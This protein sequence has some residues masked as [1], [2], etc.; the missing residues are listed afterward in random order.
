MGVTAIS[1][2]FGALFPSLNR[3]SK[4]FICPRG[5]MELETQEYRPSPVETVTTLTWYC[6]DQSTGKRTELGIFPMSLY[7]GLIYGFLLFIVVVIVMEVL[8]NRSPVNVQ[9]K[10]SYVP[11][12]NNVGIS[13]KA[14]ERM[15]ELQKLRDAN[16]ISD[17][18][19]Q[20]KRAEIIR[21]L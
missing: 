1:I 16:M 8:A 10:A 12:K 3:I 7:A 11:Q 21:D 9:P 20:R 5:E 17:D 13:G 6:V 2:G 19:Y 18:E 4:P 14:L 15:K